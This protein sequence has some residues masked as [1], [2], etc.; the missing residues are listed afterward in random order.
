[1]ISGIPS[2][3]SKLSRSGSV[4][5][6]CS[7]SISGSKPGPE[8][9]MQTSRRSG[10]SH[11]WTITGWRPP[12]D[13]TLASMALV[14]ASE[15]ASLRSSIRSAATLRRA[16]TSDATTRR[17]TAMYSVRE[18]TCSS[19][20]RFMRFRAAELTGGGGFIHRRGDGEDAGQPGD[21]EDLEN[22]R[23]RADQGK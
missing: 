12:D 3:R 4:A 20:E 8:S 1:R 15:T 17:T 14:H 2:P 5:G 9:A 7:G 6:G 23:L 13:A 22:A 18:G 16:D 11:T 21:L 10:A 19:R